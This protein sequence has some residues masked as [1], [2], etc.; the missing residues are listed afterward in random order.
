ME[1]S[2]LKKLE[3]E[4]ERLLTVANIGN[5]LG[6]PIRLKIVSILMD[7]E[8]ASWTDIVKELEKIAGRLNPN[9]VNFHLSKL[10]EGGIVEKKGDDQYFI[11]KSVK[12]NVVLKS[13][14]TE[15]RRET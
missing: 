1:E 4:N 3:A 6:H 13:M 8:G 5:L 10:I 2:E 12:D 14:L 11:A 7:H 9:T 15:L